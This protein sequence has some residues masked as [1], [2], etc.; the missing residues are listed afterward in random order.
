MSN[1]VDVTVIIPTMAEDKR[2]DSL[3][4][5]IESVSGTTNRPVHIVVVVNGNKRSRDVENSLRN[6]GHVELL[7]LEIASLPLAHLAGRRAVKTRYFCFLDDD[8]E[9]LPGTI[10]ARI[11]SLAGNEDADFIVTNGYRNMDG[12]DWPCLD[13]L[14]KVLT[15]PLALLFRQNW[16]AS[17]GAL[18]RF[19]RIGVECFEETHPY[20]EWTW[21]AFKLCM[22]GKKWPYL[23][24]RHSEYTIHRIRHP[25][26]QLILN[27]FT[28]SIV[29]C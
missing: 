24:S 12:I 26:R 8:D 10:D 15:A 23:I 25:S 9:Y 18:F 14:D 3:L 11:D 5:A 7:S 17:C 2:H 1:T 27:H 29:K 20:V 16:L 6:I 19:D 21:L 28:C 4:R 13:N 22:A